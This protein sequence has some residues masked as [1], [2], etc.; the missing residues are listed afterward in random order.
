MVKPDCGKS[1][2]YLSARMFAKTA[3]LALLAA[4]AAAVP[5][6]LRSEVKR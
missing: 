5:S 6:M 4:G 2:Q 3:S 1:Y